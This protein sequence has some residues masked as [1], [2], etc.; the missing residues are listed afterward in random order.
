MTSTLENRVA[1]VGTPLATMAMRR[2]RLAWNVAE[3]A[4]GRR[5]G[6]VTAAP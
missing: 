1:A 5:A 4:C 2:V 3:D 6:T